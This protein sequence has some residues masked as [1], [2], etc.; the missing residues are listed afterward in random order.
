MLHRCTRLLW[1]LAIAP[2]ALQGCYKATFIKPSIPPGSQVEQW[3][4]HYLFGLIGHE[5]VDVRLFC[6]GEVAS[7]RTG[8]NVATDLVTVLTLG[9]YSPR[10]VYVTCAGSAG[11]PRLTVPGAMPSPPPY[12]PLPPPTVT[13]S[14]GPT[15]PPPASIATRESPFPGLASLRAAPAEQVQP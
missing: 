2:L 5:E 13:D 14:S 11:S 15:L 1:L 6:P 7:I 3:T 10:K 12:I 9:I 4:D 8:G